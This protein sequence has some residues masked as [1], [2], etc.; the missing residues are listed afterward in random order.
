MR[1][2]KVIEAIAKVMLI[3]VVAIGNGLCKVINA[4]ACTDLYIEII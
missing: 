1:E 2:N 3:M 4:I